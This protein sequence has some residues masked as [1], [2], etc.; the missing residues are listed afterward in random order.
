MVITD[1]Q[2]REWESD[3]GKDWAAIDLAT[4]ALSDAIDWSRVLRGEVDAAVAN[5]HN[6]R[7]DQARARI[8][9]LLSAAKE[10]GK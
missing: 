4:L 7:R 5:D 9:S 1:A 3:Q 10:G 2:I 8:A 6:R